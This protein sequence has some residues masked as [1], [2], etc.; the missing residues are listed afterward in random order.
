MSLIEIIKNRLCKE[1]NLKIIKIE[2]SNEKYFFAN[3]LQN[4]KCG[5]ISLNILDN[6]KYY[7][8]VKTAEKYRFET[9]FIKNDKFND[10]VLVVLTRGV[11]TKRYFF[12]PK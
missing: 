11:N 1:K 3:V 10:I 4:G 8:E 5:S 12:I 9:E 2:Y 6:I 7:E